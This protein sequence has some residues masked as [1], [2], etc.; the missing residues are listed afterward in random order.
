MLDDD[1]FHE[2][3]SIDS[4]N[5]QQQRA[6]AKLVKQ[7]RTMPQDREATGKTRDGYNFLISIIVT[8]LVGVVFACL[9]YLFQESKEKSL[10]LQHIEEMLE[11][12]ESRGA[13]GS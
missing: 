10:K 7:T 3:F 13:Q 4:L 11:R 2:I 8:V 1:D 12:L 9:L 5:P 6:L